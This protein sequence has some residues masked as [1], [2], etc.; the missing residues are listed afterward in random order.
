[1]LAAFVE[2]PGDRIKSLL[3]LIAPGGAAGT[4]FQAGRPCFLENRK[5]IPQAASRCSQ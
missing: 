4:A 1:M 3:T 5:A 2:L